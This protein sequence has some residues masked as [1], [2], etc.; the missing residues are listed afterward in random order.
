VSEHRPE[1][2]DVH[3]PS[4]AKVAVLKTRWNTRIVD[5][6]LNA[7]TTR[8]DELAVSYAIFDVPGAFELPTA[9]KWATQSH[10]AVI[11]LGCVIRGGTPHFE[12]VAGNCARGLMDVCVETMVPCI[13]GVLTVDDEQQ[14]LDRSGGSHGD[15]GREAVDAAATMIALRRRLWD[16]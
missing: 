1:P 13:F 9:A 10:D 6:L 15:A 7:A 4:L 2:I 16:S 14:A 12:Y 8:L 5:R 11:A 3:L